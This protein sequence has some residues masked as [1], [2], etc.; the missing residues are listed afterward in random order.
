MYG[1][2]WRGQYNEWKVG[3]GSEGR[4]GDGWDGMDDL[5]NGP[6]C[7]VLKHDAEVPGMIGVIEVCEEILLVPSC[8]K[9]APRMT[10][11]VVL[12]DDSKRKDFKKRAVYW[13]L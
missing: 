5:E 12:K 11:K 6:A 7:Q 13:I 3:F 2:S 10:R 8:M 4:I 9:Y 1:R